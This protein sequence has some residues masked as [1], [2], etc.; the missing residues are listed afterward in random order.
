M[1]PDGPTQHPAL[2]AE[3]AVISGLM[4]EFGHVVHPG[5]EVTT[6]DDGPLVKISFISPIGRFSLELRQEDDD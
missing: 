3:G 1:S 6:T 5:M 4:R 2:I